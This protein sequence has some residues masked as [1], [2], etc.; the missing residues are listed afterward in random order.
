M[1]QEPWK[2]R[3]YRWLVKLLP[4]DLIWFAINHAFVLVAQKAENHEGFYD[5]EV[6]RLVQLYGKYRPERK[7]WWHTSPSHEKRG[8]SLRQAGRFWWHIY[9]TTLHVEWSWFNRSLSWAKVGFDIAADEEDIQFTIVIPRILYLSIAGERLPIL[10]RILRE[11]RSG[12]GYE[13]SLS[14]A[15]GSLRIHV[16]HCETWGAGTVHRWWIPRWISIWKSIGYKEHPGVGFYVSF[17]FDYL[18]LGKYERTEDLIGDP[19]RLEIPIEPDNSFGLQYFATF[20]RQ[21]ETRWRSHFPGR[22]R[23]QE[24][25]DVRTDNPPLHAGK[26]ENGWDQGDDGIMGTGYHVATFEEAVNKY[27]EAVYRDRKKYGMPD[28]LRVLPQYEAW[29]AVQE[30]NTL[31]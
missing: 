31:T 24:Y 29:R 30:E 10:H 2:I 26:G 17:N 13:S 21:R 4:R 28:A 25:I 14:W 23:I 8:E 5:M 1:N 7:V 19:I 6:S 15:D 22:Q 16:I 20:Q 3:F 9:S 11:A 12:Y 27:Q 18:I